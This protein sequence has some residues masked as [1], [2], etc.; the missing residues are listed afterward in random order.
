VADHTPGPWKLD[1]LE[2][3]ETGEDLWSVMA[4]A[5]EPD[6]TTDAIP[7]RLMVPREGSVAEL[8]ACLISAAP[9]MLSACCQAMIVLNAVFRLT[10]RERSPE[11]ARV[12]DLLVAAITKAGGLP[13]DSSCHD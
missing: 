7:I 11:M 1:L 10:D 9:E 6:G 5:V 12:L 8:D 13:V 3:E 2:S 4:W